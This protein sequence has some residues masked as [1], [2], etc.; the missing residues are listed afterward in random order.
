MRKNNYI[1]LCVTVS[2]PRRRSVCVSTDTEI[3]YEN[4]MKKSTKKR[5]CSIYFHL[6]RHL[7]TLQQ[8]NLKP[9]T[10]MRDMFTVI[11]FPLDFKVHV[12]NVTNP[13]EVETGGKP[14][15]QEVGPYYFE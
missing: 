15:L 5:C 11:P 13:N 3:C 6:M 8:L 9:G 10:Q 14:H 2:W 1:F 4:G 7:F 12:F